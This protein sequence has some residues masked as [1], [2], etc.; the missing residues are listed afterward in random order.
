MTNENENFQNGSTYKFYG[1]K[2]IF[3][4]VD[5]GGKNVLVRRWN[6]LLGQPEGYGYCVFDIDNWRANSVLVDTLEDQLLL[7]KQRLVALRAHIFE[8]ISAADELNQRV[9]DLE[10]RIAFNVVLY[11]SGML[12]QPGTSDMYRN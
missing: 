8:S 7:V 5:R 10:K 12:H 4:D 9:T 3:H 6:D 1:D 11:G 2:Y